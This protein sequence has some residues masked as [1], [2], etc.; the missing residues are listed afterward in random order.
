MRRAT[1]LFLMFLTA[2]HD[3]YARDVSHTTRTEPKRADLVGTYLP[4]EA[5][6]KLISEVG[7][8]PPRT[9]NIQ[10]D[11]D[12]GVRI[13]NIPDWWNLPANVQGTGFDTGSGTWKLRELQGHW[14]LRFSF[15]SMRDFDS[16]RWRAKAQNRPKGHPDVGL[17]TGASLVGETPP[18]MIEL[19]VRRHG[20]NEVMRFVKVATVGNER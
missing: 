15:S 5:T 1:C 17:S 11:A 8:Y 2:C 10:L 7:G 13:T 12:G 6:R 14:D 16:D 18:Y 4:D 9:T 19:V 3:P 20:V